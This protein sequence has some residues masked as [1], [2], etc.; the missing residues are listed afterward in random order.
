MAITNVISGVEIECREAEDDK[1]AQVI[2][3]NSKGGREA[4]VEVHGRCLAGQSCDITF[5]QTYPVR[6]A[7]AHQ[8][9]PMPDQQFCG[10][11][12]SDGYRCY[13]PPRN[14]IHVKAAEACCGKGPYA[15]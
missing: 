6:K 1:P 8:F 2:I 7:E 9:Q 10:A 15:D 13:L 11:M 12:L 3:R 4:I 5:S 14:P